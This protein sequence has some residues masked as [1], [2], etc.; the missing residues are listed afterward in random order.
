[1]NLAQPIALYLSLWASLNPGE[2]APFPGTATSYKQLHTDCYQDLVAKM[3]IYS[4]LNPEKTAG[5]SFNVAD[6]VAGNS[7]ETVWPDI[8]RYFDVEAAGPK[9]LAGEVWI[10]SVQEE[11]ESWEKEKALKRNMMQETNWKFLTTVA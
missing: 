2:P 9:E 4:S 11:W 1:M 10:M 6:A 3:H 7:W 5:G 8:C